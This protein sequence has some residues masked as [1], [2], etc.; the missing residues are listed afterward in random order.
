M[1]KRRPLECAVCGSKMIHTRKHNVPTMQ[2]VYFLQAIIKELVPF[3]MFE[4]MNGNGYGRREEV[5][6]EGCDDGLITIEI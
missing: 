5:G 6:W 3:S 1:A 2:C 4:G